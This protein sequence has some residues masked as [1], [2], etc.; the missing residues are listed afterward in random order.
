MIRA[1]LSLAIATYAATAKSF[2]GRDV[3]SLQPSIHDVPLRT[4]LCDIARSLRGFCFD[5][6]A[7]YVTDSVAGIGGFEAGFLA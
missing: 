1:G 3:P 6:T 4:M 2:F 5:G 7:G